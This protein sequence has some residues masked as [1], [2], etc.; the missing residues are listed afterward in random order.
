[1]VFQAMGGAKRF[2]ALWVMV[3]LAAILI[4][5]P[6]PAG[7]ELSAEE[8]QALSAGRLVVREDTQ[9]RAGR[10][11]VGGVGY[12]V[13]GARP[14]DVTAMLDDVRNYRDILPKTRSV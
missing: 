13:I 3:C 12:I 5:A 7:V 4:A 8:I 2:R 6:A 9:E 1:M 10:R 14:K 11:Y